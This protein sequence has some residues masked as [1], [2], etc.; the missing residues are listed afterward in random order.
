MRRDDYTV[1]CD[2]FIPHLNDNSE[3]LRLYHWEGENL[4]ELK[5]TPVDRIWTMLDC[6]GKIYISP[7]WHYVNRMDYI[8]TEVPWKEGQRDYRY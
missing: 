7:G 4:E 5:R 2:K 1:F 3:G 6:D 8:I